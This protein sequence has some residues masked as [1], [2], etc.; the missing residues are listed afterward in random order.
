VCLAVHVVTMHLGGHEV[1]SFKAVR[2]RL[3]NDLW[4]IYYI[5]FLVV[6][7]FHGLNGLYGVILDFDPPRPL[8]SVAC[9]LCWIFGI[10]ATVFGMWA[11]LA[12]R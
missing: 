10:A 2:Q 11:I 12:F 6:T 8:K 3:Q 1:L 4:L 9:G 7:L 5:V